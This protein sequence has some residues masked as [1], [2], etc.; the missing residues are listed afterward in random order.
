MEH[1]SSFLLK[2]GLYV[3]IKS[4]SSPHC[5]M[6]WMQSLTL[7]R[8]GESAYNQWKKQ[9]W[10]LDGYKEFCEIYDQEWSSDPSQNFTRVLSGEF[11]SKRL[12]EMALQLAPKCK[13][14]LS[15][16][17]TPLSDTGHL[18]A[19]QTGERLPEVITLPDIIYVSPYLRT[20]QT[21]AGLL[22][23]WPALRDVPVVEEERI[24]EQEHGMMT[25]YSDTKI[26]NVFH[27]RNA[28]LY[29]LQDDYSNRVE[30]GESQIDVRERV[31]S[32]INT[33]IR[34]HAQAN[35]LLV[36]HHLL[37]LAFMG[38]LER[39]NREQ[40]IDMDTN[41]K[42]VNCGVTIFKGDPSVGKNGQLRRDAYNLKLYL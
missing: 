30:G 34:E 33:L 13:L 17:D 10:E 28:L 16:F 42:P 37:I 38:K 8:H 7:I 26:Y 6:K 21:L 2:K 27:P 5:L 4:A 3:K 36:A 19:K 11:P 25:L 14:S 20:R 18:Q 31:G 40:F 1:I 29:E 12:Q 22:E 32:F 9:K 41:S 39:W 15:D 23:G 24:R 35:V